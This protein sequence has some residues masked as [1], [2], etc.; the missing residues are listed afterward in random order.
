MPS[1]NDHRPDPGSAFRDPG[2][3][4]PTVPP[5]LGLRSV[6]N[7]AATMNPS[8]SYT[9]R[10]ALPSIPSIWNTAFSSP[11]DAAASP[12]AR[13][14]TARQLNPSALTPQPQSLFLA[15]SS[16]D[17]SDPSQETN[18]S[19]I[20]FRNNLLLQHQ[21][22]LEASSSASPFES[23]WTPPNP[24]TAY[25]YSAWERNPFDSIPYYGSL[26]P[27]SRQAVSSSIG[28]ASWADNAFIA[29]S[30]V[31]PGSGFYGSNA[32]HSGQKSTAHLGAIGQQTPP[33]GQEG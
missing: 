11:S 22:V 21:Q 15:A 29:S 8:Q 12:Q 31:P 26:P 32:L 3:Q 13:P 7:P 17:Q 10:P 14:G 27:Q 28:N 25:Q 2:L 6:S 1:G 9:P 5:G 16:V 4:V 30:S 23:S 33:C 19:D 24:N 20:A 18:A